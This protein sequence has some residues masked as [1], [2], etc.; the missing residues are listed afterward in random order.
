MRPAQS[1]ARRS[2]EAASACRTTAS[3]ATRTRWPA[4]WAR[5]HRSTSSRIRGSRRSK[6]PSSSKTSRRIEHAGGGHGQ[7]GADVVVLALVLFAA[8]EAGPAAA[9]V[10]DGDADLEELAAVVP[11]A[12][13]GADDGHVVT[14][15]FEF[16]LH[17][18][19]Q[20]GERVGFG[21]AVVVQQPQ[22][23]HGLAVRE[24]GQVVGV[25]APGAGD[26]VPA[27]GALQVGQFL[28][29]EDGGGAGGLLDGLAEAGAAG[30]VQDAVGAERLGDQ[31][32]G[33]VRAAGVG[34]DDVLDGALLAEQPGERVGQPAGTVVGDEH[35]GHDMTRELRCGSA[36]LVGLPCGCARTSRYGPRFAGLR[37]TPAPR[38]GRGSVS[39]ERPHYRLGSDGRPAACGQPGQCDGPF[40]PWRTEAPRM[41]RDIGTPVPPGRRLS[42]P[43]GVGGCSDRGLLQPAA[44]PLGQAAPDAEPLVVGEGVLQAFGADLAGEADLLGLA[45]GAALLG[46][47]GLG[48]GLGAQR[49]LLPAEFLVR[50]R[51]P[52]VAATARSCAPL[53]CLSRPR[54]AAVTDSGRTTRVKLQ[55]CWIRA[56][57]AEI[58]YWA[59]YSLCGTKA[60]R[61]VFKSPKTLTSRWATGAA[62]PRTAPVRGKTPGGSIP[63]RH[64]PWKRSGSQSD[65]GITTVFARPACCA[66]SPGHRTCTNL[67]P[68]T[69]NRMR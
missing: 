38:A 66:M 6:P 8:V 29:G 46:E 11:A 5:Q 51:R 42:R 1:T 49:A 68:R 32:R 10:G 67:S 60:M 52:A 65:H 28:G 25:V 50:V 15:E 2:R 30:E 4:A 21:G 55:V 19:Q 24:F 64:A 47:E 12:E 62:P 59:P 20:F 35:R 63:L 3:G 37:W 69:M 7:H 54:D 27:A 22:P 33:V 26:G 36:V 53:V 23:L 9:G 45:G 34:G 14:A 13:L 41:C 43:C 39:D 17:H 31:P 40:G 57:Q 48:I 16:V 56:S 18:A 58:C 44:F 61:K